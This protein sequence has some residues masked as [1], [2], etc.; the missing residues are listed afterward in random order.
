MVYWTEGM[1]RAGLAARR[2]WIPKTLIIR[3]MALMAAAEELYPR[4]TAGEAL[5]GVV[6]ILALIPSH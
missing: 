3:N 2:A 1:L 5:A 6:A 4:A